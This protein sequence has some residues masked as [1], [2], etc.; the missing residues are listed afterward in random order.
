[1]LCV[2]GRSGINR[3]LRKVG[4]G[5]KGQNNS[6]VASPRDGPGPPLSHILECSLKSGK[7]APIFMRLVSNLSVKSVISLSVAHCIV[8][9]ACSDICICVGACGGPVQRNREILCAL[10]AWLRL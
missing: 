10:V 3:G 6:V 9:D 8:C 4:A 5:R 7:T 2:Q 1:M